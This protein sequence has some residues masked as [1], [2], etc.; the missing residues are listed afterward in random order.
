MAMVDQTPRVPRIGIGDH[1]RCAVL[2]RA[3]QRPLDGRFPELPV[4]LAGAAP[5][6]YRIV[7][8][9]R[10]DFDGRSPTRL[11]FQN[12][13]LILSL[14]VAPRL[15]L[16]SLHAERYRT[17]EGRFPLAGSE[18]G[19]RFVFAISDITP[20]EN[21]ASAE[22]MMPVVPDFRHAGAQKVGRRLPVEPQPGD[23][24]RKADVRLEGVEFGV[25]LHP[26]DAGQPPGRTLGSGNGTRRL[27]RRERCRER[28]VH[29]P[30]RARAKLH[31]P[32]LSTRPW[33]RQSYRPRHS[34]SLPPP[35]NGVCGLL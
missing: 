1:I 6:G 26:D 29:R 7:S 35:A 12:G 16:E 17:A 9:H 23:D 11:V 25:R 13:A 2:G 14:I 33:L 15:K 21:R 10:C 4:L 30:V 19:E 27:C 32:L 3:E 24:N 22:S 28:Q 5:A 34:F 8:A 31:S 20:E 18:T